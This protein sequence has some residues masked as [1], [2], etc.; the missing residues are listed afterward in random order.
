M[1]RKITLAAI[2]VGLAGSMQAPPA[3]AQDPFSVLGGAIVGGTIGGI[4][5]GRGSGIVAGAIIGGTTG[6]LIS[7][8]AELRRGQYYWWHGRCYVRY[9]EGYA[10]VEPGYCY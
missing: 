3:A 6:A 8:E 10:L 1:I 9:R 2:L 5:T 7:R 4:V